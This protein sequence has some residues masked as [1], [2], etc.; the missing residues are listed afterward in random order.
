MK[1]CISSEQ[2]DEFSDLS[3][4]ERGYTKKITREQWNFDFPARA[5]EIWT[6]PFSM[7]CKFSST[8]ILIQIQNYYLKCKRSELTLQRNVVNI[9]YSSEEAVGV[10][11]SR[12]RSL[13]QKMKVVAS[14]MHFIENDGVEIYFSGSLPRKKHKSPIL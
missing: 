2:I 6:P 5:S 1:K 8:T 9:T 13:K 14:N 3:H 12:G 4:T 7:K 10:A 11:L